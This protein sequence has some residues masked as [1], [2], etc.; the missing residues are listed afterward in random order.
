M[1]SHRPT[2]RFLLL[3][4]LAA[5]ARAGRLP[6]R[7][8]RRRRRRT[9]RATGPRVGP[10]RLGGRLL[11]RRPGGDQRER[12]VQRIG[13]GGRRRSDD[14]PDR[15]DPRPGVRGRRLG[16]TG[17]QG[18]PSKSEYRRPRPLDAPRGLPRAGGE[19]ALILGEDTSPAEARQSISLRRPVAGY[20]DP[21]TD[22]IVVV[23]T[24]SLDAATLAHEPPTP[25]SRDQQFN[26]SRGLR[27][28]RPLARPDDGRRGRRRRC[29]SRATSTAAARTGPAPD[30][31][32][33]GSTSTTSSNLERTPRLR[34]AP[35]V[36]EE[37]RRPGRRPGLPA[38]VRPALP[39][40]SGVRRRR[41]RRRRRLGRR[42]RPPRDLSLEREHR[43]GDPRREVP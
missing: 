16:R 18:G 43:A 24:E 5:L 12:R 22:E 17:Q 4:C 32:V 35:R 7:I 34:T 28:P 19:A 39:A 41:P 29:Q 14:G 30:R 25:S 20:Y 27:R 8:E 36:Q 21:S 40:R 23:G 10:A 2:K 38:D 6:V 37:R 9:R 33:M 26:L 42:E 31:P 11:A 1:R 3:C 15:G 13:G